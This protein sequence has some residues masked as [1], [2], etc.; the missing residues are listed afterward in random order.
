VK[1]EGR[2][3]CNRFEVRVTEQKTK[4]KNVSNFWAS[5]QTP[6]ECSGRNFPRRL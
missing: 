6:P 1:K 3:V 2:I 5:R 4:L